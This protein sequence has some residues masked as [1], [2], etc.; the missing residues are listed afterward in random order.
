[1]SY[2]ISTIMPKLNDLRLRQLDSALASAKALRFRPTPPEG[3]VRTIREALGM[4]LRQLAS[5]AGLSKTSVAA[6]E[7][8]EAKG[9]VQL[10]SLVRLADA[11]DCDLVYAIVPR[12]SLEGVVQAQATRAAERM[13]GSVADSMSLEDQAT[14][15]AERHQLV[16]ELARR[17]RQGPGSIWDV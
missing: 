10:D 15:E 8:N 14:S 12:D 16:R 6:V 2:L 11:M 17:L 7:K 13:V 4:S 1:M 5:R 3:W 9:S